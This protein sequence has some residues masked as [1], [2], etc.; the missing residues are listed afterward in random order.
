MSK[1]MYVSLPIAIAEDSVA[2]RWRETMDAI[3]SRE[4]LSGYEIVGPI[5][6]DQFDD[7]GIKSER[8]HDYAWY[9]GEDIRELL[10]C[11]AIFMASGWNPS[12]GCNCELAT[13]KIY[14]LDVFYQDQNDHEEA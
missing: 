14:G 13:A 3:K 6:I 5:N 1:K 9:M 12:L 11:D 4:E 10:R 7:N 8:E 2:R